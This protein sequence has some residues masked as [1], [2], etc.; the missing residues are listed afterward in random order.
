MTKWVIDFHLIHRVNGILLTADGFIIIVRRASWVGEHPNM[1]DTPGGHPEP[2]NLDPRFNMKHHSTMPDINILQ[3]AD[4]VG[5]IFISQ[6]EEL[7][8]ELNIPM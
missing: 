5:E 2:S 1:L 6:Q 4:V 8:V 7:S 3:N